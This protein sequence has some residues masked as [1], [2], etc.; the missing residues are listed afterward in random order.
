LIFSA[1]FG[2]LVRG[3]P[4]AGCC[5]TDLEAAMSRLF[6]IAVP[7]APVSTTGARDRF[8]APRLPLS[9]LLIGPWAA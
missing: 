1:D 4:R 5:F 2:Y 3:W 7:A 9:L 6:D 8:A